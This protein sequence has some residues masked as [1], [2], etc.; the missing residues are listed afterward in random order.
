MATYGLDVECPYTFDGT[1]FA[2]WKNWMA[3]N[4]KFI[5][6]QIWWIIDMGFSHV[7]DEKNATRA[8]KKYLHL[9]CQ[10]T[11]II[12]QSLSD[13]IFGEIMYMKTTHDIW[14]YLNLIY[15]RVSDDDDEPKEEAHEC[16]EH[17]HNLVIVADC[18]TS[19]SSD[20]DDD[21][22]STTSSLDKMDGDAPSDAN[23][24]STLKV[25]SSHNS[26]IVEDCSTSWSSDDD[27][28][29]T[30]SSLDEIDGSS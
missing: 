20:D 24:D 14:L 16:V 15:G 13:K 8:Q 4:F 12:Y 7:L 1:H 6:P 29:S 17:D 30:S 21:D 26:V 5:S 23:D 22:R 3:C 27:N 9:D 11:N 10:A 2:R 18:S 25:Q 28:D 19:W